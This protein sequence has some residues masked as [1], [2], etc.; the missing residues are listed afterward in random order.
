M[1]QLRS[2]P[3]SSLCSTQGRAGAILEGW[4]LLAGQDEG[5]GEAGTRSTWVSMQQL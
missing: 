1:T 4:A 3:S 2:R 5:E